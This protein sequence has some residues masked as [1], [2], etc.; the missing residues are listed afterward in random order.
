MERV[1]VCIHT[2]D[3]ISRSG[4]L[5]QLRTCP[6]LRILPPEEQDR[7]EVLLVVADTVDDPTAALLRRLRR[8]TPAQLVLVV[9]RVDDT[10]LTTAVECGVVALERRNEATPANLVRAIVSAARGGGSM[11]PDLLGRL[12]EQMGRLQRRTLDPRGLAFSGLQ[13]REIEVL[14]LVAEGFGTREIAEHL[15]YS[16]R[17]V[18]NVLYDVTNRLQLRNRSHAVAYAIREGLI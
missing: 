3:P 2:D 5:S 6:E 16:E 4:L 1:A 8:T 13:P 7:A 11:P 14:R 9:S 15:A 18:K 17:T 10:G 12:L